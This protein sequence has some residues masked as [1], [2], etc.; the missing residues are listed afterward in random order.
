MNIWQKIHDRF[1][2]HWL[3]KSSLAKSRLSKRR[4]RFIFTLFFLALAIPSTIISYVAYEKLRWETFHQYQQTAQSLALEINN[5]LNVAVLKEEARSDSDFSFLI[6]EGDPKA[7]FLQRSILS[8]YPV[9]SDLPGIVGYFQVDSKGTFSS[10]LL[11]ENSNQSD[12]Y[13]L[14]SKD[15]QLRKQL[16][17][18]LH[19]ILYENQLVAKL[20]KWTSNP[21]AVDDKI[22]KPKSK[23]NLGFSQLETAAEQRKISQNVGRQQGYNVQ[24]LPGRQELSQ[25]AEKK[26]KKPPLPKR[27]KRKE[28][29]Y[30]PQQAL[31]FKKEGFL[32]EDNN[33]VLRESVSELPFNINLFES[34]LEPFRFSLLKS[35]HFVT[36]RRVWRDN[37]RLIQGAILSVDEFFEQAIKARFERS[38]LSSFTRLSITYG[39]NFLAKYPRPTISELNE[40]LL[41]STKLS[42]PFDQLSLVFHITDMPRGQSGEFLILIA[43]LLVLALVFGTYAL[44]RL[45]YRQS[46]LAQ[47]HQD[48]IS[49]VSH[50]LKTPITSIKMYG[51]ILKNGWVDEIKREKYY[52]FIYSESERLSRLISNILQISQVSRNSLDLEMTLVTTNELANVIDSTIDS[53]IKQSG[54]KYKLSV[55]ST[56]NNKNIIL[57]IDAFIQIMINLVDNAIKYSSRSSQQQIDITF[58][59]SS[60][61]KIS[62]SV[63]DYGIG[64]AKGEVDK[65][66]E[67]FYRIGDEL[68]RD[69]KGTGIGL[70]LVKELTHAMNGQVKVINHNKGVEFKLSFPEI[71]S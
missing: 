9:E 60:K 27:A 8:R 37:N 17:S 25:L 41:S 69:S 28:K 21:S 56:I 6:L 39:D 16:T 40:E 68:T 42:D 33:G 71:N 55:D 29:N 44:F 18:N 43:L 24:L 36:Y 15:K 45:T 11:P 66:F 38:P 63:R 4:L 12:F 10:P 59:V 48:F 65:V 34:E 26:A 46:Q 35:G 22:N 53:Q 61:N 31:S 50:E 54:F 23:A 57:D 30:I 67:L 7:K 52:D 14:S 5:A 51:E 62:I 64:I 3:F 2:L 19:N 1:S 13:G 70:A 49:A 58:S 32:F 47:Q 20:T